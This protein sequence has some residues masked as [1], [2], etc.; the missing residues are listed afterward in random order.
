[1]TW[2]SLRIWPSRFWSFNW[3]CLVQVHV[4]IETAYPT[5]ATAVSLSNNSEV[6]LDLILFPSPF[7]CRS[8]ESLQERR[9]SLIF[10]I[11]YCIMSCFHEL[12]CMLGEVGQGTDRQDSI[13]LNLSFEDHAMQF[14]TSFPSSS[15]TKEWNRFEFLGMPLPDQFF[16]L[17]PCKR[18]L[19]DGQTLRVV[20]CLPL[21]ILTL[22]THMV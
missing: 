15:Y 11:P 16:P 1:V 8:L 18:S 14:L 3:V 9:L 5:H 17:L 19:R 2:L 6:E 4:P 20:F 12:F 7:L 22:I 10:A 13:N 21:L